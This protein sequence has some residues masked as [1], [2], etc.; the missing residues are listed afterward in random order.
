MCMCVSLT[1]DLPPVRSC[2]QG[3][4][5]VYVGLPDHLCGLVGEAMCVCVELYIYD[6]ILPFY[7]SGC[8]YQL[9]VPRKKKQST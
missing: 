5:Y 9:Q 6:Q 2:R 4:V 3:Y 7:I 1:G 8:I